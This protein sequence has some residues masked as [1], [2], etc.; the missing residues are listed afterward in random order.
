MDGNGRA[1]CGLDCTTCPISR[2]TY[3]PDAADLLIG[4]FKE[5][6]VIGRDEGVQE[7]MDRG[8]YCE[9]CRGSR[10]A[11]WSPDCYILQCCIDKRGLSSCHLC[12]DFPC[13]YITHWAAQED[14]YAEALR[15]LHDQ[16]ARIGG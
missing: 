5:M 1:V 12:D 7:L 3:D 2:A 9:G 15:Y 13:D 11:H 4:W 14:K 8:P 10:A 16:R 6:N